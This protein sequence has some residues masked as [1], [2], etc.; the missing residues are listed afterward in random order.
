[1]HIS[2][3]GVSPD[4]EKVKVI[5]HMTPPKN[6]EGVKSLCCMLQSNKK[7]ITRLAKK[8]INIRKLL[9]KESDFTWSK[10]WQ[11]EFKRIKQEFSDAILLHHYNPALKTEIHVDA[12][13]T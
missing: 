12:H 8:T 10:G 2:I 6:K 13:Q 9:K 3:D 4:P 1:M 5:K 11:E 7:F